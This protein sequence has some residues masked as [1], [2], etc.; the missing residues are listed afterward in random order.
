MYISKSKVK[1]LAAQL[2]ESH[3]PKQTMEAGVNVGFAKASLKSERQSSKITLHSQVEKV[4]AH[5]RA[6]EDVGTIDN[7][8]NW[9]AG[10]VNARFILL[11][12]DKEVIFFVGE[13]DAGVVFGLGGSRGNLITETRPEGVGVG[14]SFLPF[15]LGATSVSGPGGVIDPFSGREFEVTMR[16]HKSD[17]IQFLR[18]VERA[19]LDPPLE[20]EFFA[21]TLL[22]D[23]DSHTSIK[24]VLATPVY[25]AH[26]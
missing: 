5:I 26:M 17:W 23:R 4:I 15:L 10:T 2:P 11:R 3:R 25:V 19:P 22:S 1:M 8:R 16:R 9:I 24:G 18:E 12:D 13:T 20:I 21:R 6:N 14:W 7:P